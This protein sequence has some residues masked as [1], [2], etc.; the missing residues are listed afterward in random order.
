MNTLARRILAAGALAA[1]LAATADGMIID[2]A[3]NIT[4]WGLRPFS[5][6]NQADVHSAGVWSTI[7]NNYA[8][9][10]YPGGIGYRPSPGLNSGGEAFDLE[11]LHLRLT[12]D[13]L[14]VL[15]VTSSAYSSVVANSRFYLG[16]LFLTINGQQFGVVTQAANQGL[17]AGSVYRI[18]A[19]AD[20]V[21]LQNLPRSYFGN[22]QKVDN[23]YGPKA[24]IRDIAGPWA[25]AAA[26]DPDQLF[27]SAAINTA[28][29]DYG[30][31][32]NGTFL[33]E[34]A[35][36]RDVFADLTDSHD[37]TSVVAKITWG[38]GN[39]VIRTQAAVAPV[40]PEPSTMAFVAGGSLATYILSRRRPR[41]T[42]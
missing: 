8:P 28:T 1:L 30:A 15:V 25:V 27:G 23:D 13:Q 7:A 42:A 36:D 18:D 35:I 10:N 4:D 31:A 2:A 19:A 32:E 21:A 33:L 6:P 5:L 34:Y 14:Q 9:I 24:R 39:D 38:C 29:F 12:H 40:A 16:D 3:G 41:R 37:M 26:I 17:A 22:N 20:A 11:E